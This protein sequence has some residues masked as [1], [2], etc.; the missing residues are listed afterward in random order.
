MRGARAKVPR[1]E[2]GQNQSHTSHASV[3]PNQTNRTK[4]N[5]LNDEP[6]RTMRPPHLGLTL[7]GPCSHPP[8][9]SDPLS[10]PDSTRQRVPQSSGTSHCGHPRGRDNTGKRPG[11]TPASTN[12]IQHP[13]PQLS[14]E[15]AAKGNQPTQI[16]KVTKDGAS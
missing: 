1:G 9:P 15:R 16:H 5:Q 8:R 2:D 7:D 13:Q 4:R 10:P 3:E 14:R 12:V 6:C 11:T